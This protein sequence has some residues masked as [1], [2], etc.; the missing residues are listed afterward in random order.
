MLG[1]AVA[2]KSAEFESSPPPVAALTGARFIAAFC[3]VLAHACAFMQNAPQGEPL[4]HSYGTTTS[5]YAMS[6]FFVLS[7]FVIHYNYADQIVHYRWRGISNFFIARFARLYPLYI[8][9]ALFILF[10]HGDL[11]LWGAGA[12]PGRLQKLFVSLPYILTLTQSWVYKTHGDSSLIYQY[13][14]HSSLAVAWSISTEWFFYFVYPFICV[15]LSRI[16]RKSVLLG[17]ALVVSIAALTEVRLIYVHAAAINT[18]AGAYFGPVATMEHG[19]Q[20]SFFRWLVYFSPY[21]RVFEFL[22][23][24]LTAALY[25]NIS[26]APVGATERRIGALLTWLAVLSFFAIAGVMFRHPPV[27]AFLTYLHQNYG[28]AIPSAVFLFCLARYDT[29]VSRALA[30]SWILLLGEAS[31]SIYLLHGEFLE[32]AD[33]SILPIGVNDYYTAINLMRAGLAIA[34]LMAV[35]VA[36]YRF[37][38]SPSR[39]FIRR[40]LSLRLPR[41]SIELAPTV[42]RSEA[43]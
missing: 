30:A 33:L 27:N 31:Y 1:E 2:S 14:W 9:C 36:S 41:H 39:R 20:D 29:S 12:E 3:V 22:I 43:S 28:F 4:W 7:G 24:C 37:V 16:K 32:L 5:A 21:V 11:Y 26:Q 8:I 35:S 19:Y 15:P 10:D 38:E 6:Q 40:T 18:Y 13:P 25:R 17:L 42:A 23:G 34:A